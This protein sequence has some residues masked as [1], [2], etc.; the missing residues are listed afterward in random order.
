MSEVGS[1][2]VETLQCREV[3]RRELRCMLISR[4]PDPCAGPGMATCSMQ[5]Y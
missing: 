5:A 3:A 1:V 2:E 4:R